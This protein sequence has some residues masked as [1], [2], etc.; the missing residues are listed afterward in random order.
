MEETSEKFFSVKKVL[1]VLL[2]AVV[3]FAVLFFANLIFRLKS[4]ELLTQ[5]AQIERLEFE[6]KL[7]SEME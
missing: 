1:F 2:C 7:K 6:S 5:T 3:V 4:H